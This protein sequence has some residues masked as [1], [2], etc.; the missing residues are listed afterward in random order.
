MKFEGAFWS[1]GKH[2]QR[3]NA[4]SAQ[5]VIAFFCKPRWARSTR[6][7]PAPPS[8]PAPPHPSSSPISLLSSLPS[9]QIV[10]ALFCKTPVGEDSR[11]TRT[12]Q[13]SSAAAPKLLS[14]FFGIFA[15]F[16]SNC[17]R[18]L[19]FT[20]SHRGDAHGSAWCSEALP[21]WR[22]VPAIPASRLPRTASEHTSR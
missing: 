18:F 17:L 7:L 12:A 20:R 8:N 21:L 4:C 16:C 11:P 3:R 5:I 9:V 15:T 10:F 19:L 6:A 14:D 1:Y 2:A 22:F 13:R